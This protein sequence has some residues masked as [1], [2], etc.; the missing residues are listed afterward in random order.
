[1]CRGGDFSVDK[2]ATSPGQ[3]IV[4]RRFGGGEDHPSKM[5]GMGLGD[6]RSDRGSDR[7]RDPIFGS[8]WA[9]ARDDVVP[10]LAR[11]SMPGGPLT[12]SLDPG[13]RVGFGLDLGLMFVHVTEPLLRAWRVD[14]ETLTRQA[15]GNLRMRSRTLA[16]GAAARTRFGLVSVSV[17]QTP[18]GYASS[19]VL[20]P[21]LLPRLFG[22]GPWLFIA[23]ARNLLMALPPRTDPRL[24]HSVHEEIAAQVPGALDVPPLYWDGT[25]LRRQDAPAVVRASSSAGRTIG[26]P[27]KTVRT[28]PPRRW[29]AP[30]HGAPTTWYTPP[31]ERSVR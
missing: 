26:T 14:I 17:L 29:G 30:P 6:L 18:D 28:V 16:A 25:G 27:G 20:A 9:E 24:A 11:Q 2:P 7:S 19:L 3:G 1:M 23:P 5:P 22:D 15:I 4:E 13:L 21:D 12:V 31:P 10:L 8:R